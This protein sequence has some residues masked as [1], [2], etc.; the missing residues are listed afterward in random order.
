MLIVSVTL[1]VLIVLLLAGPKCQATVT[2][3]VVVI[4]KPLVTVV[5][6]NPY[7]RVETTLVVLVVMVLT[8]TDHHIMHLHI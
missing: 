1:V 2:P 7:H 8:K 4:D 3:I 5:K 6:R